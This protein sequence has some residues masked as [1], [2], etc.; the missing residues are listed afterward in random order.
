VAN[1]DANTLSQYA[2]GAGGGLVP[3]TPATVATNRLPND[4]AVDPSGKYVYAPNALDDNVSLFTIGAG[5]ALAPQTPATVG[6]GSS[7]RNIVITG[8]YQ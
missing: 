1:R 2:I 4:V 3:L 6:A 5:G 8:A 7:A